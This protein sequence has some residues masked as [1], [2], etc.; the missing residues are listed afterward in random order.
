MSE[1]KK[2]INPAWLALRPEDEGKTWMKLEDCM[3]GM[4]PDAFK[5]VQVD[6]QGGKRIMN[7]QLQDTWD[8]MERAPRL[9]LFRRARLG[10]KATESVV[11]QPWKKIKASIRAALQVAA[12]HMP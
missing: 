3:P 8:L 4:R 11:D 5:V 6:G 9:E 7:Q 10:D 1:L 12:S 2:I